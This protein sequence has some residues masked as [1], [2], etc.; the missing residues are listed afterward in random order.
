[1]PSRSE[2]LKVFDNNSTLH[3]K[4]VRTGGYRKWADA[5]NL[6][7][8]ESETKT[9]QDFEEIAMDLL[10]GRGFEVEKMTTKHPFDL[11]INK[12]VKIDVKSGR[13]YLLNGSRCHS[14]GINKKQGS[15]DI[16]IILALDETDNI[17]RTF[18]IPSHH[19]KVTTLS[20][21]ENSSYNKYIKRFDVI[22]LYS[23][24]HK[25]VVI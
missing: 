1:M 4:I 2:I 5:L 17:E 20:I 24:F 7:I 19:L 18:I 12:T 8:K 16:Y 11:L 25:S 9:G 3:N 6:E 23:D 22:N 13:P 15:C 10:I 14:F 21:G